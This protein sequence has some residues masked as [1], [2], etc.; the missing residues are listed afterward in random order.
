ME[1]FSDLFGNVL[2]FTWQEG[3]MLLI[4]GVLIYLAIGGRWSR[5]CCSPWASAP[6]W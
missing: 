6:S 2:R 3:V 1:L 5:P 4:G